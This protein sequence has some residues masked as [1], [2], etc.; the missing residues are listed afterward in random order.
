MHLRQTLDTLYTNAMR[1]PGKTQRI[2]LR[3]GLQI[4]MRK[5]DDGALNLLVIRKD[6]PASRQEYLT[7]ANNM[8][9]QTPLDPIVYNYHQYAGYLAHWQPRIIAY[10]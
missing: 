9:V 7:V 3:R 8:P 2:T 6:S 4:R 10:D 5:D 1:N